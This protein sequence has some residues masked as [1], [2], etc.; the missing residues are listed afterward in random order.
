VLMIDGA[1]PSSRRQ[2]CRAS[3]RF[4]DMGDGRDAAV[5]YLSRIVGGLVG[6]AVL[7][8]TLHAEVAAV[9]L[10]VAIIAV[11]LA[12]SCLMMRGAL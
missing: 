4:L 11:V 12:A 10:L 6:A 3:R 9:G 2:V 1:G 7:A 8:A 5:G